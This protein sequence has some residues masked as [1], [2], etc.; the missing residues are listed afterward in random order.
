MPDKD[1]LRKLVA[2]GTADA[3]KY[4]TIKPNGWSLDP[5]TPEDGSTAL[6]ILISTVSLPGGEKIK[7]AVG[8]TG[9]KPMLVSAL[10]NPK[11]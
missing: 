6:K 2:S 10:I 1:T 5:A 11:S 3:V 8:G 9:E 4:F 7:Y